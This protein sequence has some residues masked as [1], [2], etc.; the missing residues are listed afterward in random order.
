MQVAHVAHRQKTCYKR[1][2]SK[3]RKNIHMPDHIA[4]V[5]GDVQHDARFSSETAAVVALLAGAADRLRD[6]TGYV[7]LA[8]A[9][10]KVKIG[11]SENPKRRAKELN[12]N[13]VHC[14]A[15]DRLTELV[16]HITWGRYRLTGEWFAD[17]KEIE[18]W[19]QTH[20]MLVDDLGVDQH[21]TIAIYMTKAEREEIRVAAKR[22]GLPLATFIRMKALEAVR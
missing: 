19:F 9:E 17:E 14:L 6:A 3:I 18:A 1:T 5:I 7:Y 4:K 11:Y 22:F 10:G 12:A 15:G 21:V 20:P 16:A 2:M 13:L 8:R